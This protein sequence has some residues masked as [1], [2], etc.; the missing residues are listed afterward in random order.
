[1][2]ILNHGR[3]TLVI[4]NSGKSAIWIVADRVSV[5]A[6]GELPRY[7]DINVMLSAGKKHGAKDILILRS[8]EIRELD[9]KLDPN[10]DEEDRRSAIEFAAERGD[11]EQAGTQRFSWLAGTPGG[12][13]C[14]VLLSRFDADAVMNETERARKGKLSFLGF[15]NLKHL[16]LYYHF[17]KREY[18]GSVFLFLAENQGGLAYIE[19]DRI[20]FRTLPFGSPEP[21]DNGE[22][23]QKAERRLT[24]LKGRDVRLYSPEAMPELCEQIRSLTNAASV[25]DADWEDSLNRSVIL[26][27]SSGRKMISPALPPPKPKD[28][29]YPGT[30][31]AFLMIGATVLSFLYLTVRNQTVIAQ[32]RND[33]KENREAGARIKSEQNKLNQLEQEFGREQELSR[34]LKEK[35]RVSANFLL[36]VNLLERYSLQY[37]RI[38]SIEEFRD[39]IS[40]SGESTWQPDLSRFL[41]HFEGELS[42]NKLSFYPDGLSKEKD[43][44]ILFRAHITSGG[45]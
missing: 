9:V 13:R 18:H 7:S 24:V 39:G 31:I 33:L 20:I 35:Q 34:L 30:V 23:V 3:K 29:N 15:V 6:Q 26:F 1:M 45:K 8:V 41:S 11:G 27:L 12:Y 17:S 19:Q 42:R 43:G 4:T 32:Y 44:R 37:T 36:I 21:D 28:P 2:N 10:M 38:T 14:G 22:W 5:S 40:I 16:L 25:Q